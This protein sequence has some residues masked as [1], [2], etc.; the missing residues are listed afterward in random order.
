MKRCKVDKDDRQRIST[1][2]VKTFS[3]P[4]D[5][6]SDVLY[7]IH[8]GQVA[9]TIVNVSDSLAIVRTMATAFQNLLPT[10]FHAKLSSPVNTMEHLKRGRV[11]PRVHISPSSSSRSTARDGTPA[12]ICV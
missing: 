2:L 9:P 12:N 1:E 3:H 5:T 8:N 4:L 11:R 6:E 7:N 10:G